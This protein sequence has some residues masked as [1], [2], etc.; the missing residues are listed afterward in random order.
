MLVKTA[1]L[2]VCLKLTMI[3]NAN[4]ALAQFCF[5]K[6]IVV[7]HKEQVRE[8]YRGLYVENKFVMVATVLIKPL[9]ISETCIT[10]YARTR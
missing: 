10:D 2:L 6:Q 9:E 5:R 3:V 8:V 1:G 7:H 4:L